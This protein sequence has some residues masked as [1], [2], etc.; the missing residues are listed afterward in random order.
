MPVLPWRG[1]RLT[2]RSL[3]QRTARIPVATPP[4]RINATAKCGN[5]R[6]SWPEL[7]LAASSS[8]CQQR[9]LT[10]TKASFRN[11]N[12]NSGVER[13]ISSGTECRV[14]AARGEKE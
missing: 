2:G 7:S 12:L 13:N 9:L 10:E 1:I 11:E 3:S 8:P 4:D 5:P 6:R 14:P